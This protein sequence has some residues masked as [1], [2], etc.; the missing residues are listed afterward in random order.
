MSN[1]LPQLIPECTAIGLH[2]RKHAKEAGY[3]LLERPLIFLKAT[4]SVIG[5]EDIIVIGKSQRM[6]QLKMLEIIF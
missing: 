3:D 6:C 1:Y 2:Y 4:S 5:P